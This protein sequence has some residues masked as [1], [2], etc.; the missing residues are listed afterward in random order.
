MT[1]ARCPAC[2][3]SVLDGAPWCTLCYADLRPAAPAPSEP[4]APETVPAA[5]VL[6][7]SAAS[8]PAAAALPAA[9]S[10]DLL[11]PTLDAP[12]AVA[13]DTARGPVTWP[14]AA[15]GENVALEHDSCPR[16]LTPFLAGADPAAAVDIPLV[17]S[18]RPL[19]ATKGSHGSLMKA[20][21]P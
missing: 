21:G 17:G 6:E 15:C 7:P 9:G 1:T 19:T 3:A 10:L 4:P 14:C 5:P 16:C 20:T 13:A 18:L 11:D 2:G 12:V 8:P